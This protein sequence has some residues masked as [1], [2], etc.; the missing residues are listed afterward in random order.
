MGIHLLEIIGA[1]TERGI[2]AYVQ[3]RQ[4]MIG[5]AGIDLLKYSWPLGDASLCSIVCLSVCVS[6]PV[7]ALCWFDF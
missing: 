6:I 2:C 5:I 1:W 3:V 7:H 4:I